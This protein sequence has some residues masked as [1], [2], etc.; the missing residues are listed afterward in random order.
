MIN[1]KVATASA[2]VGGT[3]G[4]GVAGATLLAPISWGTTYVVVTELLPP[5][6][7]LLVASLRVV[8]AGLV[9]VAAGALAAR[10]GR[11]PRG[12]EWGHAALL[13]LFNFGLFFPL[14]VAA[15]YRLP[16]GVAAAA[17]GLQPLLVASVSWLLNGRRPSGRELAIGVAAALGVALVVLRP[18]AAF[19]PVGVLT[20]AGANAS[21]S[22]GVVLTK[23]FPAAPNRL[24]ST[25]WQLLLGGV[26]LVPL[27][28]LV[29]GVPPPVDGRAV[30]GFAYLGL[31]ATA[32]A[33]LL[34]FNGVRRLPTA[35]PPL[36]GLA[37]PVTG[38]TLGW[39]ILGE[40]L[41]P[42]QLAGF[43]L[44]LGAIA[45]GATLGASGPPAG[46]GRPRA[47]G[48]GSAGTGTSPALRS[49]VDH[50]AP[51]GER[52]AWAACGAAGR[53]RR[54][55]PAVGVG[56]GPAVGRRGRPRSA[57]GVSGRR[58]RGG[59]RRRPRRA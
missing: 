3:G 35:A 14:L 19:D 2:G 8:P 43:A 32:V 16:G 1:V 10:Q 7:P 38:A 37:A 30:G 49:P 59:R 40:S 31:G 45:Y 23:R 13:A 52:R 21:F 46:P 57:G 4:I 12:T 44:T 54:S 34:W 17:G 27:T 9:L 29:E 26:L 33:F 15:V 50:E 5:G 11:R 36:L 6:R 56:G 47:P 41:S 24:A 20:A 48:R 18:G 58:G 22:V 28:L 25:G 51:A 39:A 42:V 55:A 53:R